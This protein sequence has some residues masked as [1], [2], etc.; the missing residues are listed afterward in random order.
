MKVYV[1][2]LPKNCQKCT[3][4]E[5]F[6]EDAHGKGEHEV[7]CYFNGS[8]GNILYGNQTSHK[9][10]PLQT[11]ADNNKQMRAKEEL[12]RLLIGQI[13]L[14]MHGKQYRFENNDGTWY[15][16]ESCRDLT[17]DELSQEL[18]NELLE[19]NKFVEKFEK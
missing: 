10:C 4:C 8:F 13:D 6:E 19:L 11:I 3:F 17:L 1:D 7:A 15:S 14:I 18:L 5:Y 9:T 2:E 16:R 12:L